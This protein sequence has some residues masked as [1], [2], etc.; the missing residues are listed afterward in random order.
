LL[1]YY[2]TLKS[3]FS[4]GKLAGSVQA[5]REFLTALILLGTALFFALSARAATQRGERTIGII[6]SLIALL[7]AAVTAFTIVP[8]IARRVHFSRWPWPFSFSITAEGGIY[9]L[10]V[11][12]LSLAALNTGNNLLFLIL[13]TLLSTII[14]SGIVARSSLRSVFV[15]LQVPENVFEGEKISIKVSLKNTRR[16]IPS[17]SI[18]VEDLHA[19]TGSP[20][21]KLSKRLFRRRVRS[22]KEEASNGPVLQHSAYFPIIPPGETRTEL[23]F[24]SFPR[25]GP[26]RVKGFKLSTRFPFGFFRRGERVNAEGEVLVYPSIHEVSSFFHLLPFT[27]GRLEGSHVGHGESLYAI[28]KYQDGESARLVDWKATAKTGEL[29]AREYA[30]EEESKFCLILDTRI[31]PPLSEDYAEQFERAVSLAASLAAHFSDESVELEFLT[32]GKYVARGIGPVHLYRILR[33][34]AVVTCEVAETGAPSD[35]RGE[36]SAVVERQT[37]QEILSDKVFKIIIT[38]KPRGSFPG[39]IWRSSHVI[40][41]DEL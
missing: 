29:M 14:I 35:L 41:F 13:A 25:R 17:F 27:P 38:S 40:Y 26:Y 21:S 30:R 22:V 36:L 12:L 5:F 2:E 6:L 8:R 33:S 4:S 34:L 19:T 10:A 18:S 16:V 28:R 20:P 32:P 24:Q 15:S 39:T 9:L 37:L 1:R 11:F 7:L 23:V 3:H 31:Q